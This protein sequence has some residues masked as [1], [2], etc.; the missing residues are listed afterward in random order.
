MN[1]KNIIA[2][3]ALVLFT[4]MFIG[5]CKKDD[6]NPTG[7]NDQNTA[8]VFTTPGTLSFKSTQSDFSVT[9]IF[10]TTMAKG[11]GAGAFTYKDGNANLLIV[12]GYKVNM[13]SSFSIA[14][15]GMA[16]TINAIT[17]GSYPI[18]IASGS[19]LGMFVYMPAYKRNSQVE[20]AM[21]SLITGS[22]VISSLT[23]STV[24]GTVSG[25][26]VQMTDVTK[27]ITI[28]QGTFIVPIIKYQPT[29]LPLIP[30]SKK[31]TDETVMEAIKQILRKE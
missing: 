11:Q 31:I 8:N 30:G 14:F 5:G 6:A 29:T 18:G 15:M 22:A 10:D 12:M 2:A 19:K 21:Y 7:A 24:Q 4:L 27:T 26:G 9:G 28:T 16:D 20:P 3:S 23:A 1:S 17:T 13:D 25:T